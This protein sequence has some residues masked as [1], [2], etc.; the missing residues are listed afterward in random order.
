MHM[1]VTIMALDDIN[2]IEIIIVKV[3][4][5]MDRETNRDDCSLNF[6]RQ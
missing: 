1:N 4:Y 3:I 5:K 6:I 2:V